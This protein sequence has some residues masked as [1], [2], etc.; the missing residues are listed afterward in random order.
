M[1]LKPDTLHTYKM[2]IEGLLSW[3][4]GLGNI[5]LKGKVITDYTLPARYYYS[6][7]LRHL[8]MGQKNG[9]IGIPACV[10]ELGPGQSL[11]IGISALLSGASSY[12][13]LDRIPFA[14]TDQGQILHDLINLFERMED[15]P[16]NNEFKS[17]EPHLESYDFPRHV[18]SEKHLKKTLN[19][20]RLK[21]IEEALKA[22]GQN[23]HNDV[24]VSYM[25]PWNNE[26][27]INPG[28]ID[29]LFS[30][31]VLEHVDDP[32]GA[33][34]S[35]FKWLK[36]GAMM[37]HAIDFRSHGLA[38][39][40]NGHWTYSRSV[41][42][43]I[44]GKRPYLLNRMPYSAHIDLVRK[45]GFDIVC[46]IPNYRKSKIRHSWLAKDFKG[47]SE[48]DLNTRTTFIQAIK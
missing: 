46:D 31:A 5:G 22:D 13:A 15:I 20:K 45:S 32:E 4:P 28:S 19:E 24:V 21:S 1:M 43:L 47:L 17:V 25:V 9:L 40:W 48:K 10:A 37:S 42:R 18:L 30:Q 29:F 14:S 33:Y 38:H 34:Q 26:K 3:L 16:D 11:G 36:P 27:I 23:S 6:V 39:D 35:I 8:V 44:Q 7:W 12:Y 41:W 2:I